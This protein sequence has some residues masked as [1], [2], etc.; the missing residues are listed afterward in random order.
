MEHWEG[1]CERT[2]NKHEHIFFIFTTIEKV[3]RFTSEV[4]SRL[5]QIST[6]ELFAKETTSHMF[7]SVV[8]TPQYLIE[9]AIFYDIFLRVSF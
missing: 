6:V 7:E 1:K 4:Y 3:M 9:A 2:S 8:N 5:C